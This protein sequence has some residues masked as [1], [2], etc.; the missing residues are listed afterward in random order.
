M[1]SLAKHLAFDKAEL[2]CCRDTLARAFPENSLDVMVEAA[3]HFALSHKVTMQTVAEEL[4]ML[5]DCF[6]KDHRPGDAVRIQAI[7]A[8][9]HIRTAV[10]SDINIL[11]ESASRLMKMCDKHCADLEAIW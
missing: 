1:K 6:D 7:A 4:V 8:I 5:A 9:T 3:A 10:C 11:G 2:Q